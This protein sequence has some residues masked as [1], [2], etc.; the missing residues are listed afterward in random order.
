[1]K[2]VVI[3]VVCGLFA[4]CW[5]GLPLAAEPQTSCIYCH[6]NIGLF[7]TTIKK[8]PALYTFTM[9]NCERSRNFCFIFLLTGKSRLMCWYLCLLSHLKAG[10]CSYSRSRGQQC[11]TNACGLKTKKKGG[12][13]S[14]T[15]TKSRSSSR[16]LPTFCTRTETRGEKSREH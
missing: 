6:L 2:V 14:V 11:T 12:R 1:M 4:D 7:G 8:T 16:C 9:I 5:A 10:T 13:S 3:V 15:S